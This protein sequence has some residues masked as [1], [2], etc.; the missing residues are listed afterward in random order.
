MLYIAKSCHFKNCV[1]KNSAQRRNLWQKVMH[2]FKHLANSKVVVLKAVAKIGFQML[3]FTD[4]EMMCLY[5][6]LI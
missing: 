1:K 2:N 6:L 5:S 4:S 3:F